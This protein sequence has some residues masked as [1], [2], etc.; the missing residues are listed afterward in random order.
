MKPLFSRRSVA[1]LVGT[2]VALTWLCGGAPTVLAQTAPVKLANVKPDKLNYKVTF[3]DNGLKVITLEDH[4][5]PVVTVQVWYRVGSA[6]EPKG[7]GGFAHLFE[8]MMFKGSDNVEPEQHAR[9]VEE[10]G[11]NY[12]A[13]TFFDRTRYYETASANTLERL[14][15]LES[16][17]MASLRI[18]AD[19]LK[20][21]RDVVKEEYRLRVANTPYGNLLTD[22][23]AQTFPEGHPYAHPT[24]GSIPDLENANL[25]DV[26]AFHAEYYRPD[27]A[28]L[29]MVGD[30]QTAEALELV[31]K[32]FGPIPKSPDGRFERVPIKQVV[33]QKETRETYYDKLAP[34]PAIGMS[35]RLPE[36]E[37]P[38]LPVLNVISQILSSGQSSRLYRSLVRDKQLAVA[39]QGGSLELKRGGLYFFFALAN[40][41]K[42]PKA[43]EAALMEE[44]KQLQDQKVSDTELIK[45]KNQILNGLVFG[46][47]STED[48]A[49]ALGDADLLYGNPEEVNRAY[50]KIVKVTA[51]DIQRVARTYFAPER[52]NVFYVLPEAMKKGTETK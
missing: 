14:L 50:D 33:Q 8:H 17:R 52:R 25:E 38:D 3:L 41:G 35:F 46:R 13:D 19:N 24:I 44:V 29:V 18:N 36:A 1:P 10:L 43:V 42:D 4:S 40:A 2:A 16:D 45:A 27:N 30:F 26:R 11:A 23:L 22:I 34:L 49:S 51:D 37:N 20:S 47:L 7:K 28:T 9:L 15:F 6:E 12:N 5:A 39:A 48:K 32:Y 31:K 21:E